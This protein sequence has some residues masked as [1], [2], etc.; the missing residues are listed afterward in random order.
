MAQR[1]VLALV[2]LACVAFDAAAATQTS[3][4]RV[5]VLGQGTPVAHVPIRVRADDGTTPENWPPQAKLL[6]EDSTRADGTIG[7]PDIPPGRYIVLAPCNRLPGDWIGGT[8]A[9]RLEVLPGRSTSATLTLRRGAHIVGKADGSAD[10]LAQASV[11]TET[12]TSLASG[13]PML[14]PTPIAADGG[15]E[16]SKVPI[17]ERSIVR[18][19][20]PLG[21]GTL[22]VSEEFKPEQAE[23]VTR[24]W[25]LPSLD[26]KELGS[27]NVRLRDADG[28]PMS[29]GSVEFSLRQASPS[30]RY[31]ASYEVAAGDTVTKATSLPPGRYFVR[32][33]PQPGASPFWMATPESLTVEP[34]KTAS[35]RLRTRLR[36]TGTPPAQT[37]DHSGHGH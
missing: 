5:R 4:I 22:S 19:E 6:A 13:C 18:I 35:L 1:L 10:V 24:T 28:K 20:M 36:E 32:A 23:T 26:P 21:Q 11:R 27:A 33:T 3:G 8:S 7:F 29:Q 2:A 37:Q 14:S 12:P 31:Q 25:Q 30:W 34:G 16:V 17:G 9:T 15:F